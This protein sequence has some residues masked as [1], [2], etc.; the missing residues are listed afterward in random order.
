MTI[1]R[2]DKNWTLEIIARA[3]AL[4][5]AHP[6][7]FSIVIT[8]LLIA[9]GLLED[10]PRPWLDDRIYESSSAIGDLLTKLQEI[11]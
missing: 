7:D 6:Y 2:G 10:M 11:R 5:K 4:R 3:E 8:H 1:M 9:R